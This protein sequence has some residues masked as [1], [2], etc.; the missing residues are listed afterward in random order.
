VP[1]ELPEELLELPAPLP[2]PLLLLP[3]LLDVLPLLPEPLPPEELPPPL[4]L[5]ALPD[6]QPVK[7]RAAGA[8]KRRTKAI[9]LMMNLP[10]MTG[11]LTRAP[12]RAPADDRRA[13]YGARYIVMS[14]VGSA[15]GLSM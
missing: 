2:L 6:E 5:G 4:G 11:S 13:E 15:T 3:P 7:E 1:L 12:N 10:K 14:F 8:A 9:A